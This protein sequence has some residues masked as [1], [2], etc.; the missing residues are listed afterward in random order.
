MHLQCAYY[1]HHCC[2]QILTKMKQNS[3]IGLKN[4][5][6]LAAAASETYIILLS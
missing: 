1:A 3:L 4:K 2:M 5:G 6:I